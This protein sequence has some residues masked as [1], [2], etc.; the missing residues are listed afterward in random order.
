[1][2]A[3]G[4]TTALALA[5]LPLSAQAKSVEA[6]CSGMFNLD[7]YTFD[8]EQPQQEVAGIGTGEFVMTEAEI[9]MTGSFGTYRFELKG[10]KLYQDEKD[11]GV[12]CTYKGL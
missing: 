4:L 12:H 11:T 5:L 10:G 1:M 9:T 3:L 8:T 6:N 2:K 7:T